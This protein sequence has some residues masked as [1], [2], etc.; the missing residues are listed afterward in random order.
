MSLHVQCPESIS[1][2]VPLFQTSTLLE[3]FCRVTVPGA[4]I[5]DY[6]GKNVYTIRAYDLN[7]GQPAES[8][9]TKICM[10]LKQGLMRH[11]GP[12]V[13]AW[14]H[15]L[16]FYCFYKRLEVTV[17]VNNVLREQERGNHTFKHKKHHW[18]KPSKMQ[19]TNIHNLNM[20]T[21]SGLGFIIA[22]NKQR[23]TVAKQTCFKVKEGDCFIGLLP[24]I[25]TREN[26]LNIKWGKTC[27]TFE[28]HLHNIQDIYTT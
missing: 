27:I 9:E 17:R 28:N 26:M 15:K 14:T 4:A 23:Y 22:G 20:F 18:D 25:K 1:Q 13:P 16:T 19:R 3:I 5:P 21:A 8:I 7:T 12:T 6:E 24:K 2:T 11:G 10:Q